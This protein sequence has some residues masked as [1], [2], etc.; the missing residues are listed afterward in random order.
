V[1]PADELNAFLRLLPDAP[2]DGR[3]FDVAAQYVADV[4]ALSGPYDI[5]VTGKFLGELLNVDETYVSR[6]RKVAKTLQPVHAPTAQTT[7]P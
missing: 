3:P 7:H 4:E 5:K 2:A 1:V 6:L